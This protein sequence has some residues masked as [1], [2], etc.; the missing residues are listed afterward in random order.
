[1]TAYEKNVRGLNLKYQSRE[2]LI[3]VY[4][5]DGT[6]IAEHPIAIMDQAPWVEEEMVKGAM[7]F[8]KFLLSEAQR[9]QA[10]LPFGLQLLRAMHTS[11]RGKLEEEIVEISLRDGGAMLT[12]EN[13]EMRKLYGPMGAQQLPKKRIHARALDD[14]TG[15]ATGRH[16]RYSPG[17]AD[18]NLIA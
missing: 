5:Q 14:P 2:R 4:L 3:S 15:G 9:Q 18:S 10:F 17:R 7:V 11:N 1:M 13:V 12:Q 8:Q 6:V 16:S